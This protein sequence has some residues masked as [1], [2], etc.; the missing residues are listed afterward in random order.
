MRHRLIVPGVVALAAC[1]TGGWL[2]QRQV[3]ADRFDHGPQ[4]LGATGVLGQ[5]ARD[6]DAMRSSRLC[7]GHEIALPVLPVNRGR[8]MG[9][10][11]GATPAF[12]RHKAHNPM[13]VLTYPKRLEKRVCYAN[14]VPS[15]GPQY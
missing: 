9:V 7:G 1:L 8:H 12:P 3:A 5:P 10:D 14:R 11:R 13:L 6:I 2:L 4:D 15:L